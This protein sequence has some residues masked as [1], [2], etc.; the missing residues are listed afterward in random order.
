MATE[1]PSPDWRHGLSLLGEPRYRPGFRHFDYVRP[2]AP[3][4]G[5]LRLGQQG[6]FDNFNPFVS[7]VKGELEDGLLVLGFAAGL[8]RAMGAS[9]QFDAN[10]TNDT[11]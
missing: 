4:G 9:P 8:R 1:T 7:G 11:Q 6:T 3:K 10:P 2:D 5:T